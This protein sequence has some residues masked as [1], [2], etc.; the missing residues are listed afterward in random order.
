MPAMTAKTSTPNDATAKGVPGGG[1]PAVLRGVE[2]AEE[3]RSDDGDT[4]RSA[5]LLGRGQDP[6]GDTGRLRLHA[7]QHRVQRGRDDQ[8]ATDALQDEGWGMTS[9]G[10]IRGPDTSRMPVA[11]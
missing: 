1:D 7:A 6:G 9:S 5:T 10:V 4:E 3:D 11:R 2:G 8:S